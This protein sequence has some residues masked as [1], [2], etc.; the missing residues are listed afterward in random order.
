VA[1][2]WPTTGCRVILADKEFDDWMNPGESDPLAFKRLLTP[3]SNDL[4]VIQPASTLV[5][6]V[7]YDGPGKGAVLSVRLRS[8]QE[9]AAEMPHKLLART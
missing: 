5:N 1:S 7:R 2:H 4:L 9:E 3:A 6:N 8:I